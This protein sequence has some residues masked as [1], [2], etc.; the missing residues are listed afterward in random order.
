[1]KR[2]AVLVVALAAAVVP[3]QVLYTGAAPYVQSFD[4]LPVAGAGPFVNNAPAPG[5]AGWYAY[6][7]LVG[8]DDGSTGVS[9]QYSYGAG[10]SS[11]RA[12]GSVST[13]GALHVVGVR[14]QNATSGTFTGFDARYLGEQWRTGG[15]NRPDRLN[16]AYSTNAN[17]LSTGTWTPLSLADFIAPKQDGVA[18]ALDGNAAP[19]RQILT[20][21]VTGLTWAPGQDLWL[22]WAHIGGG[23]GHGLAV[24][25]LR[26][27]ATPVPEP[28][29]IAMVIGLFGLLARK[30]HQSP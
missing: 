10:G 5:M 20:A 1:M 25:D 19:Y 24:D 30:R 17:A 27:T 29:S 4:T 12:L 13:Y 6:T 22:R 28:G 15:T 8:A 23:S 2:I 7:G 14:I 18:G 16:F 3:A 9:E 21:S 11:D 26:F